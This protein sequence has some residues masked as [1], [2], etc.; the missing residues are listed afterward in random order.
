VT[1]LQCTPSL[2]RILCS[3]AEGKQALAKL[4]HLFVGGEALPADLARELL[5]S[6]GGTVT[7]MYGPTETTIWSSTHE[8][9]AFAG[10]VA[11]R[12][13]ETGAVPIG[14]PIANTHFYVLGARGEPLPIG[15]S[16]ELHIGGDGVARGY[17]DRPELQAERFVADPYARRAGARMYRS[18]D[19]V[20]YRGDG[21]LEFLGRTDHQIKIRGH[22]VEP[23]EIEALLVR[24][25]HGS[26]DVAEA[27]VVARE[28]TPGD[29]RLIAYVVARGAA[30]D[31]ARLRERLRLELPESM[32]PTHYVFLERIPRT[33]NGKID[34]KAL[35]APDAAQ[36]SRTPA[37]Q[38]ASALE[39]HLA[40]LWRDA[41]GVESVGVS[42]NFFD[43]GGHS[44]LVVRIHRRLRELGYAEV[45]LT[46]LFRY[47]TIRALAQA[48]DSDSGS[49]ALDAARSRGLQRRRSAQPRRQPE[50]RANAAGTVQSSRAPPWKA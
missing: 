35:P 11:G 27:V 39:T 30:P 4:R 37:R 33:H 6:V 44:L 42:D 34:R 21:V 28:D 48:L 24:G 14:K 49:G 1:H 50:P 13:V 16:G 22:R 3:S 41:L 43:L 31:A 18:G 47:P 19:L 46:D 40:Q 8:L 25:S 10:T 7:N 5:A 29:Q 17:L 38:P 23:G 36:R 32:V 26:Q 45:A 9:E 20:R 12:A 2:A 15:V